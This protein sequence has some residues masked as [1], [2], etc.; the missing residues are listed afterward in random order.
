M[1]ALRRLLFDFDRSVLR[2]GRSDEGT[3]R[4]QGGFE[5]GRAG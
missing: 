4:L 3:G 1:L 5:G 2:P